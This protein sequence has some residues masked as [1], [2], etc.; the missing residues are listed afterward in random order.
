MLRHLGQALQVGWGGLGRWVQ[1]LGSC[2]WA[3]GRAGGARQVGRL[4]RMA[5][6]LCGRRCVLLGQRRASVVALPAGLFRT[7]RLHV[8]GT[9]G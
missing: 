4:G 1:D 7:P 2:C 3:G 9:M 6:G 5:T 8:A